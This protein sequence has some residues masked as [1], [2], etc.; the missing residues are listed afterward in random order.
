MVFPVSPVLPCSLFSMQPVL[1]FKMDLRSCHY[2]S[3]D[4]SRAFHFTQS[5]SQRPCNDVPAQAHLVPH[6]VSVCISCFCLPGSLPSAPLTFL[7]FSNTQTHTSGPFH[8]P[9]TLALPAKPFPNS[10][11]THLP[12]ICTQIT[13]SQGVFPDHH[14]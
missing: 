10:S 4:L 14:I 13:P 9:G 8:V 2:C 7:V 12:Q 1:A 11:H 6:S 5:E 3:Q